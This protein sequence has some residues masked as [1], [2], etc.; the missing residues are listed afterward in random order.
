MHIAHG[1]ASRSARAG[2]RRSGAP[3]VHSIQRPSSRRVMACGGRFVSRPSGVIL[4]NVTFAR[5]PNRNFRM[6]P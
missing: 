2:T 1:Q 4:F 5:F 6:L 3:A